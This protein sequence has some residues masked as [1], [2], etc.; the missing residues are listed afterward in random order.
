MYSLPTGRQ[1]GGVGPTYESASRPK[2][3]DSMHQCEIDSGVALRQLAEVEQLY[4][5]SVYCLYN[6]Q[7]GKLYVGQT[8]DLATRLKLHN[9]GVFQ[10]SYTARYV[11]EWVLVYKEMIPDRKAALLREKQLKSYRGREFLK[12][13]IPV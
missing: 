10:K 11:G 4:M 13:Y 5:Y 12:K 8:Q 1:A 3:R 2:R 9:E 6:K 7:H